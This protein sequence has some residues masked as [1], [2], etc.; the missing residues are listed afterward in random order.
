MSKVGHEH[1]DFGT[2]GT[3]GRLGRV[4]LWYRFPEALEGEWDCL[5]PALEEFRRGVAQ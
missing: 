4:F 2:T 1:A 5:V 3:P